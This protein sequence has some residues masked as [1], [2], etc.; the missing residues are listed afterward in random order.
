AAAQVIR[1]SDAS[2]DVPFRVDRPDEFDLWPEEWKQE[3]SP[4]RQRQGL[5]RD[6]DTLLPK[7][8]LAQSIEMLQATDTLTVYDYTVFLDGMAR[9]RRSGNVP[10]EPGDGP[11]G[12]LD[13]LGVRSLILPPATCP[14]RTD[15]WQLIH[16]AVQPSLPADVRVW[17]N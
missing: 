16:G 3:S 2:L 5:A 8:A 11:P 15:Q 13:A 17:K 12:G 7:Y 10:R 14:P 1:G 4:S 9:W 6:R